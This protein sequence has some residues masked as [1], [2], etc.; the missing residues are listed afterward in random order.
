MRHEVARFNSI[1]ESVR[2]YLH[3]LNSHADYAAMR[4][5]R[6]ELRERGEPV[7]GVQLAEHLS[8]YSERRQAYIDELQAFIQSNKL[9]QT[10]TVRNDQ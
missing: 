9:E 2:S 3:N 5:Y 6:A 1:D 8:Q 7:S 10:V 4:A